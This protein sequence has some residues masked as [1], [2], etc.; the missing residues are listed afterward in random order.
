M[1]LQATRHHDHDLPCEQRIIL[2]FREV[3]LQQVQRRREPG[4]SH[5]QMVNGFDVLLRQSLR[6]RLRLRL[7][8]DER[9]SVATMKRCAMLVSRCLGCDGS[10]KV[11]RR[12]VIRAQLNSLSRTANG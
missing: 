2:R 6:L 11:S 9:C 7:R 10:W 5:A 8:H 4:Q 3:F 12:L 1:H